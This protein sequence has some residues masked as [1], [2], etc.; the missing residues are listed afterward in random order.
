M[1]LDM[2][3]QQAQA[4]Y[5]LFNDVI[6]KEKPQDMEDKLIMVH[7]IALYKKVRNR[8]EDLHKSRYSINATIPEALA[9]CCFFMIFPLDDYP[10]EQNFIRMHMHAIDRE[11]NVNLHV[12]RQGP[13]QLTSGLKQLT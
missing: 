8:I 1:K 5:Q 2:S 3:A 13:A 6:L 9:Y 10:Y 4:L 11:V 12:H 7:M